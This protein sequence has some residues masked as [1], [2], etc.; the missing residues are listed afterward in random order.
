MKISTACVAAVAVALPCVGAK[1]EAV[2]YSK[3]IIVAQECQWSLCI[4]SSRNN[5][6]CYV[7]PA[8]QLCPHGYGK[9]GLC[10][11]T[12]ADACSDTTFA[13]DSGRHH[14]CP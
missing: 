14:N 9:S 10:F 11:E 8:D 13:C 12:K 2:N 4:P 1:A 5:S 7:I 6:D 3:R